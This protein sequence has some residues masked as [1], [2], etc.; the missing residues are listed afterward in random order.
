ME[1]NMMNDGKAQL[2]DYVQGLHPQM[3]YTPC[4][5]QPGGRYALP[6]GF[7]LH[8]DVA[9]DEWVRLFGPGDAS[10]RVKTLV[11]Y[12]GRYL[13]RSLD[14]L[15]ALAVVL[16]VGPPVWERSLDVQADYWRNLLATVPTFSIPAPAPMS[17]IEME[18]HV[19][20]DANC[21]RV[22]PAFTEAAS[23][24]GRLVSDADLR[25]FIARATTDPENAIVYYRNLRDGRMGVTSAPAKPARARRAAQP[26]LAT[27]GTEA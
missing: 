4:D 27:A 8:L 14:L 1:P 15:Q 19:D 10:T 2:M 20:H 23:V 5:L 22:L 16:R 24:T 18:R 21:Q 3:E 7:E 17:R 12:G 25:E 13:I 26:I 11:Q 6:T 9:H